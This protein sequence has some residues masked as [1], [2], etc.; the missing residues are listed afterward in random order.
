ML[1]K[2]IFGVFFAHLSQ[3][4]QKKIDIGTILL[5]NTY[6]V[7]LNCYEQKYKKVFFGE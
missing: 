7:R 2:L 4:G 5:Q 3:E 1:K 6:K